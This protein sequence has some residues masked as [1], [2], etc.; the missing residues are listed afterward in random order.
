MAAP[1]F[2]SFGMGKALL[3]LA[4]GSPRMLLSSL[5]TAY[6]V[7]VSYGECAVKWMGPRSG[8]LVTKHD[9]MLH[10]IHEGALLALF[11]VL[12]TQGVQ[13]SGKQVGTLDNEITFS[14][15]EPD[16]PSRVSSRAESR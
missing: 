3:M 10:L 6:G 16:A 12:G 4:Q 2:L 13:V 15:G 7:A 14:W 9:F 8:L 11:E 1:P 5:P